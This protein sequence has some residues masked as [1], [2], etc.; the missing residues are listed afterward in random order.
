R[1]RHTRLVSDWSSDVCSSDLI[2]SRLTP[3]FDHTVV[4]G[5]PSA[6]DLLFDELARRRICL[7]RK[8]HLITSGD[9]ISEEWRD[10]QMRALG[11]GTPS[12]IVNVYGS[13][14][15]GLLAIETP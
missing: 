1:R 9:R 12:S 4:V 5:Y 6:L 8:L 3:H 13:A 10:S 7:H 2:F 15:G 14:D 11:I